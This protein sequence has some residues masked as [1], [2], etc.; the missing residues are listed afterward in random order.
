[1]ATEENTQVLHP[2]QCNLLLG[3]TPRTAVMSL[4]RLE[5]ECS[6]TVNCVISLSAPG[7]RISSAGVRKAFF[8]PRLAHQSPPLSLAEV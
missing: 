7:Y 4:K 8:F 1:M 5:Y 3:P 2:S 6:L